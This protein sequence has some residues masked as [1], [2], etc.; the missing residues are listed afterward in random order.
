M[1]SFSVGTINVSDVGREV[2]VAPLR[3]A[4][5]RASDVVPGGVGATGCGFAE[6]GSAGREFVGVPVTRGAVVTRLVLPRPWAIMA[7]RLAVS[8][9]AVVSGCACGDVAA[10]SGGT[11]AGCVTVCSGGGIAIGCVPC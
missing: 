7:G 6:L 1:S 10:G 3:G 11:S 4:V 9:G 2:V 8:A 5:E